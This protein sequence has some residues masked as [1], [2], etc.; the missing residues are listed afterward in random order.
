MSTTAYSVFAALRSPVIGDEVCWLDQQDFP[1][2][3]DPDLDASE[4]LDIGNYDDPR[5]AFAIEGREVS[6][7]ADLNDVGHLLDDEQNL[8]V[9]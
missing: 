6:L 2:S 4:Y 9:Y 1:G 8:Y 5:L 3:L 7:L